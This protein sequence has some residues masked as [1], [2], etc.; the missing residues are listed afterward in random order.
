MF[1]QVWNRAKADIDILKMV[2]VTIDLLCLLKNKSLSAN[3]LNKTL[4]YGAT[5]DLKRKIILPLIDLEYISMTNPNKPT[6]AKQAYQLT[7]KGKSLF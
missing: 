1:V 5:Y 6:S 2:S 7:N 4:E 3:T